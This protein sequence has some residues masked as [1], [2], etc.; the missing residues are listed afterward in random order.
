MVHVGGSYRNHRPKGPE[1]TNGD[2]TIVVSFTHAAS[3][4]KTFASGSGQLVQGAS[5]NGKCSA[6]AMINESAMG[7][8]N[9]LNGRL[10]PA[11]TSVFRNDAKGTSWYSIRSG[12]RLST[13]PDSTK[14]MATAGLPPV[15]NTR[16]K[17]K[18]ANSRLLSW[19][20]HP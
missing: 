4:M 5:P 16:T 9:N 14:K 17:G 2:N 13:Y 12:E 7:G 1:S 8:I 11:A 18:V 15:K 3:S 6:N 10:I 19:Y 20:P